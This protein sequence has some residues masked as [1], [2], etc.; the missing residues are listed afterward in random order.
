M[1]GYDLSSQTVFSPRQS[2]LT[3]PY[4]IANDLD[5]SSRTPA[6]RAASAEPSAVRPDGLRDSRDSFSETPG[7]SRGVSVDGKRPRGGG[8]QDKAVL[9]DGSPASSQPGPDTIVVRASFLDTGSVHSQNDSD[10]KERLVKGGVWMKPGVKEALESLADQTGLSFS[11]TAAKGLE[12]YVRAK[13]QNQ[14]EAL[15][16]PKM[17][18]MMRREIR[19][20]DKR[21]LYFEMRNAI[22]AEQTRI[23]TTDL[24][25]RQ[26]LKEGMS[27][28]EINTKLDSAYNM[29]RDNL[30][31][32]TQ[33][34]QLKNL[35]D[36]WW[37]STED[38]LERQADEAADGHAQ[39]SPRQ[40]GHTER[41]EAGTGKPED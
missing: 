12:I 8:W 14:Q 13:I 6:L 29:A 7:V 25:K 33:T 26:L 18:A 31:R 35:L 10:A 32:K 27:L 36:A 19:A 40:E 9:P 20:S 17:Q 37:R 28:K 22:A 15:F 1:N 21:H 23:L 4:H 11:K 34:P 41:G 5:L 39:K 2:S 30:L 24:Y 3:H 38:L 16:E